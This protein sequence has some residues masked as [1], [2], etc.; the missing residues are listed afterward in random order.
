M[1]Y[2]VLDD[3]HKRGGSYMK[4]A[5]LAASAA[6]ATMSMA[7]P[8]YAAIDETGGGVVVNPSG[9]SVKV[10][11]PIRAY[12]LAGNGDGG[13]YMDSPSL[14][15]ALMRGSK[16]YEYSNAYGWAYDHSV[17]VDWDN[18]GIVSSLDCAYA[19]WCAA[20]SYDVTDLGFWE[21]AESWGLATDGEPLTRELLDDE[22][23]LLRDAIYG[24]VGGE[25]PTYADGHVDVGSTD[26]SDAILMMP[27]EFVDASDVLPAINAERSSRGLDPLTQD[28]GLNAAAAVRA[29]EAAYSFSHERP[30]TGRDAFADRASLGLPDTGYMYENLSGANM[31]VG[32]AVKAFLDE[33]DAYDEIATYGTTTGEYGHYLSLVSDDVTYAGVAAWYSYEDQRTTLAVFLSENPTEGAIEARACDGAFEIAVDRDKLDGETANLAIPRTR[34]RTRTRTGSM[35]RG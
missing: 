6:L 4:R 5:L 15:L 13:D 18:D 23:A 20:T 3:F 33:R 22:A 30:S 8:A 17:D 12:N 2:C 35:G 34:T 31:G 21:F 28:A 1:E 11:I 29:V 7:G 27:G 10:T 16:A 14:A 25:A 26:P 32:T 9:M 24:S 19:V